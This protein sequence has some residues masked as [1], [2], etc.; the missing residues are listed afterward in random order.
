MVRRPVIEAGKDRGGTILPD[1][2]SGCGVSAADLGLDG[3]EV[4]D[5]GH[6]FPGNR[7]GSGAGDLDQ[8]AA[9]VRPAISKLDAR[10]GPVRC[11]QVIASGIAV[12]LQDATEA[13]QDPLGVLPSPTGG[14]DWRRVRAIEAKAPEA[15]E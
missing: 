13:L 5:Q 7:R 12:D 3:V 11:A 8:L 10:T 1:G 4:P 15:M 6:A 9:R 14:M 2:Q